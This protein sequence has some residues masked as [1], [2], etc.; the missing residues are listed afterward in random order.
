[1]HMLLEPTSTGQTFYIQKIKLMYGTYSHVCMTGNTTTNLAH[2]T[3]NL[4]QTSISE[5]SDLSVNLKIFWSTN[6]N[7][8][9]TSSNATYNGVENDIFL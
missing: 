9:C 3:T 5:R 8:S 4:A 1:M 2:T 7:N 6:D